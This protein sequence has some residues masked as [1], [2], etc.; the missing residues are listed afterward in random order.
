MGTEILVFKYTSICTI[1]YPTLVV[2]LEPTSS[3][4]GNF[5]FSVL[6]LVL[7]DLHCCAIQFISLLQRARESD[8]EM[9]WFC[10]VASSNPTR[11]GF[12]LKMCFQVLRKH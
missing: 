6:D 7:V 5:L 8:N 11:L 10:F 2:F 1:I 3:H 9:M 12:A 4:S